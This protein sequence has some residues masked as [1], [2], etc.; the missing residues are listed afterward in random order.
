MSWCR[1]TG[2]DLSVDVRHTIYDLFQQYERM[3]GQ[4]FEWDIS[5][6]T[7]HLYQQLS[8]HCFPEAAK[9]DYIYIDEVCACPHVHFLNL[10]IFDMLFDII[11][12]P[13]Y[14]NSPICFTW[15][16]YTSTD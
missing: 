16:T 5:E 12:G 11:T 3:K 14:T 13:K 4:R 6:L 2:S 15:C 9:F 1:R 7:S 8:A 10:F